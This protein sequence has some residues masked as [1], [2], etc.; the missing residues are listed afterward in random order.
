VV[1]TVVETA[2]TV[3]H[4]VDP[5][6][7]EATGTAAH[8]KTLAGLLLNRAVHVN[9]PSAADTAAAAAVATVAA[10]VVDTAVATA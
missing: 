3:V 8:S 10:A 1:E 6:N 4:V 7:A 9:A 5:A 2:A